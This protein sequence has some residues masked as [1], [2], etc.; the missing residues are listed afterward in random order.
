MLNDILFA[1]IRTTI[2]FTLLILLTRLLGR[3]ALSQMTFFDFTVVISF[4][5]VAANIGIGQ[6]P[7]FHSSVTVLICLGLLGT[8]SGFLHIKH[9][10]FRKLVNSEPLVIMQNGDIVLSNMRK[11][12]MTLGELTSMLRDKNV[13][14]IN[15]VHYAIIENNGTLSILPKAINKPLTPKDMQMNPI[16]EGL[17]KDIIID[18]KLM[19]ENLNSTKLTEEWILNELKKKGIYKVEDVFFAAL[20]STGKLYVSK[21]I[22]GKETQG[23]HG[24]E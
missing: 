23:Q 17:T 19:Y 12:R 8:L 10:G 5:S 2:S 22:V 4:G 16:D 11:A 6:T 3:K 20:D 13:F 7:S 1:I 24:I 9:L 18:G 15:E 14:N 21:G